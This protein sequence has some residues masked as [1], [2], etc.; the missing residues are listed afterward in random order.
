[1][2]GAARTRVLI[3]DDH[4][5]VRS[6]LAAIISDQNDL[7][8]IGEAPDGTEALALFREREPDV[9][10]VDLSLPDIDGIDLIARMKE[11]GKRSQYVVLTTRTGG[12]DINRA[13]AAGAHAY[14][15]KDTPS[16]ELLAALRTVAQGGR[17]VPPTV[18]RRAEQM[19][20]AM[21]LTQRE[22]EVLLWL[23]RGLSNE[24]IGAALDITT[25]TVKSHMR[26]IL[27]KLGLKSRSEAVALCL[28]AGLVHLDNL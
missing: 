27:G 25:E 1:M 14:L 26:N 28:R 20:N 19:P 22:R 7:E 11:L 24:G 12:D 13:L 4:P 21:E 9:T 23:A 8:L 17:Y 10:L 6:G 3:V 18:G 15:F 5:I 2:M 16:A